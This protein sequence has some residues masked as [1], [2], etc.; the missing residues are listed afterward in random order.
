MTTSHKAKWQQARM[1]LHPRLSDEQ[2]QHDCMKLP[3]GKTCADCAHDEHCKMLFGI[4]GNETTC[5]FYPSKFQD[6]VLITYHHD[7]TTTQ[8]RH[9]FRALQALGGKNTDEVI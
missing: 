9:P 2:K 8:V 6:D 3:V 7:G 1:K 5:D 4:T